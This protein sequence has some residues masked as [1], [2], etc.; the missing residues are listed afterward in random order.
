VLPSGLPL[1][2]QTPGFP[3]HQVVDGKVHTT[4]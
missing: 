1:G 2:D 3:A 4:W